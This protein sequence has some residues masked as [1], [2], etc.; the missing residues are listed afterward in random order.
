MLQLG[1]KANFPEEA[2]FSCLRVRVGVQDFECDAA[3]VPKI[4]RQVD[5][6]ERSLTDLTLNLVMAG[7]S[8][9]KRTDRVSHR[10]VR[11][12]PHEW[13]APYIALTHLHVNSFR[14]SASAGS[15]QS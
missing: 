5:R 6:G 9:S 12:G 13:G 2:E 11:T 3:I 7:D 15:L 8:G 1:E 10:R 14:S 4:A